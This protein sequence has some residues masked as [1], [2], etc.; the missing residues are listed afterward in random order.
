MVRTGVLALAAASLLA[1]G[2]PSA[3]ADRLGGNYRGPGDTALVREDPRSP[4]PAGGKA[5]DLVFLPGLDA[6]LR[7]SAFSGRPLLVFFSL[8]DCAAC[9]TVAEASFGDAEIADLASRFVPVMADAGKEKEFALARG[10]TACPTILA[11]D[12]RGA[13][14]ARVEGVVHPA[15]VAAA[16]RRALD[17]I[18]PVRLKRPA[19]DLARAAEAL[20]RAREA[21]DWKG[22]LTAVARIES[23]GHEGPELEAA[24]WSRKAAAAEAAS[25]LDAAKKLLEDGRRQEA[26]RVLAGIAREFVGLD[27]AF[28]AKCLLREMDGPPP[29]GDD[30]GGG[31]SG[32]RKDPAFDERL[33][34]AD[35]D[36]GAGSNLERLE[37]DGPSRRD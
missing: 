6:G 17:R 1:V 30:G 16:L 31:T 19:R 10:L 23:I 4:G 21:G 11:L 5:G 13:E 34:R 32:K 2:I 36:L 18:G 7:E 14:A 9:L 15:E 8:P 22:V 24:R 29:G 3:R 25:R 37:G 28:E 26:R 27:E 12:P 35:G 33:R 20:A